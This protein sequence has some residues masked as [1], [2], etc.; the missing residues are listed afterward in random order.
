MAIRETPKSPHGFYAHGRTIRIDPDGSIHVSC[1]GKWEEVCARNEWL[2]AP[3][4]R[5]GDD[6]EGD[7]P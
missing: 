4:P 7:Q 3:E 1:D 6:I 2:P 5:R